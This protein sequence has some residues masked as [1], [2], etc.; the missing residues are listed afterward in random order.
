[1]HWKESKDK[2]SILWKIGFSVLTI[3]ISIKLICATKNQQPNKPEYF[4]I[5]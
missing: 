1:M 2:Q 4:S 3:W 5:K